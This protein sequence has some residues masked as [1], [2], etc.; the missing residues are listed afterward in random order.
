MTKTFT[1]NLDFTE[2]N[3][4]EAKLLDVIQKAEPSAQT[5][6]NILNFSKNLAVFKSN[7]LSFIEVIKS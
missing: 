6:Q 4:K 3:N 1:P 7:H 5:I 2:K